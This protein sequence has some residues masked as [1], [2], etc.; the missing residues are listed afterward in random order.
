MF[1]CEEL[2]H[3]KSIINNLEEYPKGIFEATT[4]QNKHSHVSIEVGYETE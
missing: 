3:N 4:Q 1:E 2:S